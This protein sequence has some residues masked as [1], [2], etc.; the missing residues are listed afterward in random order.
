MLM[1]GRAAA[2]VNTVTGFVYPF[3]VLFAVRHEERSALWVLAALAVVLG[4]TRLLR[5]LPEGTSGLRARLAQLA[6]PVALLVLAIVARQLQ[7]A[8]LPLFWPIAIN[9]IFLARFATSLRTVPM[10]E[11]FARLQDP[12]LSPEKVV[13]CRAVTRIWCWFFLINATISAA[14][15]ALGDVR[16]WTLYTGGIAY[17]LMGSIFA[18]EMLVRKAKFGFSGEGVTDRIAARLVT[19]WRA[20]FVR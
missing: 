1:S 18:G 5:P 14:L 6:A 8:R 13:H 15:A 20:A 19:L 12:N 2:L 7:W 11:R 16:L 9:L 4:A 17:V 3:A 10:V